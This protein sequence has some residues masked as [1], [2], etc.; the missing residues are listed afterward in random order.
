VYRVIDPLPPRHL[1][2]AAGLGG[3]VYDNF[4][5]QYARILR[6]EGIDL[7]VRN[8]A[9][10]GE[11]LDLL[12]DPGSGVQAALSTFDFT[13]SRDADA[14]YSLGGVFDAVIF[15]FYRNATPITIFAQLRG[16]RL[17]IGMPGTALRAI[18]WRVLNATDAIDAST[19]LVDLDH[20]ESVDAL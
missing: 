4:A 8:S 12:R 11:D 9:G 19:H 7:E 2:I 6:R 17:S 13:Q 5:R 20:T 10:A 3:S 15:I 14:L 16:K 18:L 1:A